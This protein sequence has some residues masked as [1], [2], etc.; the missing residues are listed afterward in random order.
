MHII[1]I[2]ESTKESEKGDAVKVQ[3]GILDSLKEDF[4]KNMVYSMQNNP[5]AMYQRA[6]YISYFFG[7]DK[8]QYLYLTLAKV[9]SYQ[10]KTP[11]R[12]S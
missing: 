11:S 3:T 10:S 6:T 12:N 9:N 8:K 7:F 2:V 5:P 4:K 1:A